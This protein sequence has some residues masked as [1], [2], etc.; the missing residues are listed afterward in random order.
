MK[1]IGSDDWLTA[2]YEKIKKNQHLVTLQHELD[3]IKKRNDH[4]I[5]MKVRVSKEK[6]KLQNNSIDMYLKNKK[7]IKKEIVINQESENNI[8]CDKEDM[9]LIIDELDEKENDSDNEDFEEKEIDNITKVKCPKWLLQI[10]VGQ[11]PPQFPNI[12]C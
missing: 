3:I 4:F 2:E 5:E 10:L 8:E 1:K 12:I 7:G 9:D 11:N 6:L